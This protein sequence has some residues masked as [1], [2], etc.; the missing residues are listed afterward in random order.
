MA[1]ADKTNQ[2]EAEIKIRQSSPNILTHWFDQATLFTFQGKITHRSI[3]FNYDTASLHSNLRK[4]IQLIYINSPNKTMN[5]QCS[6]EMLF[7]I[8]RRHGFPTMK[9][10]DSKCRHS[11]Q[12][13]F[14]SCGNT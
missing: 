13:Y 6:S 4:P 7:Y 1:W 14:H 2:K 3:E 12:V 9:T 11:T 10:N 5:T 8:C